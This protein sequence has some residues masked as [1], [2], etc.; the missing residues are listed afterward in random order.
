LKL[1]V[2]QKERREAQRIQYL[3]ESRGGATHG[4]PLT[5]ERELG[6]APSHKGKGVK[7]PWS[8]RISRGA[9]LADAPR[10]R[11]DMHQIQRK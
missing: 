1:L 5:E 6:G 3:R 11:V 8:R 7:S 9:Y 10:D 2:T 4:G